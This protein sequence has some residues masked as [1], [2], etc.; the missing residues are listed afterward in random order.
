MALTVSDCC[1][2]CL[3][4]DPGGWHKLLATHA[5]SAASKQDES[6]EPFQL[7]LVGQ[8]K[9]NQWERA[10]GIQENQQPP[11]RILTRSPPLPSPPQQSISASEH[12]TQP[13]SVTAIASQIN[14]PC[15]SLEK[16]G[17]GDGGRSEGVVDGGHERGRR[18]GAQGP[19]G[20]LPLEQR[21]AIH[22]PGRQ[23]QRSQLRAGKEAGPGGGEEASGQ[24]GGGDEDSH[25]PQ[26]LGT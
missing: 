14:R 23:G 6:S 5:V 20:P 10:P 8:N 15:K 21:A 19:G 25:V 16:R 13:H 3:A 24:G 26:L 2:S 1:L 18:G 12:R 4:L 7:G 17:G 11:S 22:P 9:S